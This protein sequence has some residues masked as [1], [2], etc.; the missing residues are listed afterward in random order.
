MKS[1]DT[2]ETRR[3]FTILETLLSLFLMSMV[4]AGFYLVLNRSMALSRGARN[5]Y[6]AVSLCKN[7]LERARTLAYGSL[8]TLAESNERMDD[9]GTPDDNGW[10]MRSTTVNTN[11]TA[12]GATNVTQIVVTI[13]IRDWKK[14]MFLGE[15]EHLDSLYCDYTVPQ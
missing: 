6:V 13:K 14:N 9:N 4:M 15:C 8:S 12:N 10:F 11:Y 5:H 7:R 3:G 1:A 2:E